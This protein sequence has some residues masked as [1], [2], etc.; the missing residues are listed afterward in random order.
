[1]GK[2]VVAVGIKTAT[3]EASQADIDPKRAILQRQRIVIGIKI[4]ALRCFV[5]TWLS[6]HC[7]HSSRCTDCDNLGGRS[8]DNCAR[9]MAFNPQSCKSNYSSESDVIFPSESGVLPCM[10]MLINGR[11][12]L[13]RLSRVRLLAEGEHVIS[14]IFAILAHKI[15][16]AI[17]SNGAERVSRCV[18]KCFFHLI[19]NG[20]WH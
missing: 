11:N 18:N 13:G 14:I 2:S 16:E 12:R 3:I 17:C 7:V 1:M 4:R 19:T 5:R 8:L 10:M 9:S 20:C 15:S 6:K